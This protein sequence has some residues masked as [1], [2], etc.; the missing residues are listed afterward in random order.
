MAL[1]SVPP[2]TQSPVI[3]Q[4]MAG[5]PVY[6]LQDSLNAIGSSKLA[7]DGA[8]GPAT[9]AAVQKFQTVERL[10]VD[11][12]A[13]PAT[14]SKL[15]VLACRTEELRLAQMPLG[16]MRGFALGEGGLMLAPVNVNGDGTDCGPVQYHCVGPPYVAARLMEAFSTRSIGD[17]A[18]DFA[19]R[20]DDYMTFAWARK[21]PDP[22]E[23][24]GR[25]AAL[26]HNW[27]VGGSFYATYG[28]APSPDAPCTWVPRHADGSIA[29]HFPDGTEVRTRAD[30]ASFYA[31]LAG[32][33]AGGGL[34]TA[35]ATSWR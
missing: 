15:V 26:A 17:A 1:P 3:R 23:A 21:Q 14:Q 12:V 18:A 31:G 22:Y 27:P 5:W 32:R 25:C 6:A 16:L 19:K 9:L 2:S 20:R 28:H 4:G 35:Y 30:W 24:A 7:A 11:G 29:C 33:D 34:V 8:F 13:G 10:V